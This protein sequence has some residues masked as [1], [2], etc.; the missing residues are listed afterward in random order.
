MLEKCMNFLAGLP[1]TIVGGVFLLLDLV[2]HVAESMGNEAPLA[3]SILGLDPSWLTVVICGAPLVYL[4]L[5]R[6]VIN[7]G[8][9]RISSALLISIAMF[10]AIAIDELFAAGEVAFIMALGALLEEASTRRAQKGLRTLVDMVPRQGRVIREGREVMVDVEAIR[11]GDILR[12]HPGEIVPADGV[13]IE[14]ES[15]IDQSMMTGESL[16]VDKAAGDAVFGGTVNRFG[17]IDVRATSVGSE[18]SIGRLLRL[19]KEAQEKQAPIA[20]IADRCASWLVP[21][22][23]LIA[24][25]T[26]AFTDDLV[27]AV[28]V[29][30]VFCPC[31]LVL[32]TPTAIM[33][34]IGQATQ[35]GVIVKSGA[36]LE[37]L[38]HID[39][40]AFDKTGTLTLGKLSVADVISLNDR[41]SNKNLLL[42]AA[43]AESRSEHPLGKA[44][45][46][47][48]RQKGME[49][50]QAKNFAMQAG[51]GISADVS[52]LTLLC[53]N[54]RFLREV[55][56]IFDASATEKLNALR[57]EGKALILVAVNGRLAGIIALADTIRPSAAGVVAALKKM[58]VKCIVLTG[59]NGQAARHLAAK[60]GIETVF[61]D[62]LPEDKVAGIERLQAEGRCVC[63]VGDG[64]NDAPALKT[65]QASVAVAGMG[66]DIAT[67]AAGIALMN[68][69]IT[70]LPYLKRLSNATVT[71]IKFGISLSM[72]INFVAIILSIEGLLTP[73][74]GAL[75]HNAGSCLVVLI[76]AL[77]YDRSFEDDL[78]PP[79]QQGESCKQLSQSLDLPLLSRGNK[80]SN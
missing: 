46:E 22:A 31:A 20:R 28:T 4:A 38:G 32:A 23:L 26:Y 54:E 65:A 79:Y 19:V 63:M 40:I 13:V 55:G 59:D 44:V 69:D 62:L 3:I 47:A 61:S 30:V 16:P 75:V 24:V 36:V 57:D 48:A 53:G 73:T 50:P 67:D 58:G 70:R 56:V 68:D 34:A 9:N 11:V 21:V 15:S 43:A 76:A 49:L 5:Y 71:T 25:A 78:T 60:V 77:L 6:L 52:G 27:K 2:P 29:L 12:I 51:K 18:S 42:L 8:I 39:T 1:M 64:V 66:S 14:G 45:V 10:A 72:I 35:H 41:Y 33:A 74:T 37:V 7:K 80:Q 17:A